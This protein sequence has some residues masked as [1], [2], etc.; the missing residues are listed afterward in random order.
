MKPRT[1]LAVLALPLLVVAPRAAS[2]ATL[3]PCALLTPAD[4]AHLT[5]WEVTASHKR[6]YSIHGA[7]GNMCSLEAAQGI[8][9]V[10]VP[11]F[12]SPYPGDAALAA[13][14]GNEFAT[15]EH[16]FGIE[17]TT[18][19]GTSYFSVG[20]QD[21]AVRLV[22]TDHDPSNAEVQPFAHAVLARLRA[23]SHKPG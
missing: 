1:A 21:V 10:M 12:G 17:V 5:G 11:D 18:V 22:P 7:S 13:S 23:K 15:H 19:H 6:R 9:L 14:G 3:T 20:D 4:V 2:A 16:E 8:V